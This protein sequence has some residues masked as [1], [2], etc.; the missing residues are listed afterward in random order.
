MK[1][2]FSYFCFL[3]FSRL[4]Q[5][6][7]WHNVVWW[8]HLL[9]LHSCANII[10]MSYNTDAV[11]KGKLC[12]FRKDPLIWNSSFYLDSDFPPLQINVVNCPVMWISSGMHCFQWAL[13]NNGV[14]GRSVMYGPTWNK[15][16]KSIETFPK[17]TGNLKHHEN[18]ILWEYSGLHIYS[19]GNY[20][21]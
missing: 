9:V 11:Q 21:S 8:C 2:L 19:E 1:V 20:H 17:H 6:T 5:L 14:G 16:F 3:I 18:E 10:C 12:E 4:Q 7:K 15:Y 13:V